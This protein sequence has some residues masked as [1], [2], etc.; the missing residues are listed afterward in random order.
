MNSCQ[1]LSK[2]MLLMRKPLIDLCRT[3]WAERHTAYQRFY[4]CYKFIVMAMEVVALGLHKED[5]SENFA[6]ATWDSDSKSSANSLLH[7]VTDLHLL[8]VFLT[9]FRRICLVS[10]LNYRVQLWT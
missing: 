6:T 2:M 7:A 8:V 3:R 1:K 9:V 10:P 5:L 4:Q